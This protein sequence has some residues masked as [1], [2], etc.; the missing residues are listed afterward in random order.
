MALTTEQMELLHAWVDG[1]TTTA[2]G[3]IARQLIQ[4][5][6]LARLYVE[7]LKRL[8][9]LLL[10]HG[11]VQA[12]DGLRDR[13]C[14][15]LK[16]EF[17][18]PVIPLPRAPWRLAL[19]AVAAAVVVSL[20]LIYGPATDTSDKVESPEVAHGSS[21]EPDPHSAI[22][23]GSEPFGG[24]SRDA[25]GDTDKGAGAWTSGEN[26]TA[27]PAEQ[28]GNPSGPTPP[29]HA[30]D[31]SPGETA[32]SENPVDRAEQSAAVLSLDRGVDLPFELSLNMNRSR[33]AS[34]L[35][36]YND[37]LIVSS[38][39][40]AARLADFEPAQDEKRAERATGEPR[41]P[42]E[43][44]VG[45]DFSSFEG[46]EVELAADEVPQLLAA[47]N[48]LTAEQQYGEVIVP[49]DL[50]KSIQTTTDT[51]EELQNIAREVERLVR[52][53]NE[54]PKA[55]DSGPVLGGARAYLPPD[56]QRDCV[57]KDVDEL[58]GPDKSARLDKMLKR[59]ALGA[60]SN[61]DANSAADLQETKQQDE[62][63]IKLLIRL[64]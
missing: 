12:P 63:K 2:D 11:C 29:K 13:V 44:F 36:V 22:G 5:D 28:G 60:R 52:S 64:R 50:R 34:V 3:E 49:V 56:V 46:V 10:T 14:A 15:A 1:E 53:D 24:F 35:Q 8:R 54:L 62:R 7:E 30:N 4:R 45:T 59:V 51:V 41:E 17:A 23:P 61:D 25:A 47:L 21:S 18:A 38:M 55:A 26:G 19:T 42:D 37:L 48:R 32:P 39:Y 16:D 31:T 20:A 9:K 58:V 27:S 33:E 43:D 6:D 40:G 57:N